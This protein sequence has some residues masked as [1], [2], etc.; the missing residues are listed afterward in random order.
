MSAEP[1][2]RRTREQHMTASHVDADVA[3]SHAAHE[4]AALRH[5]AGQV[6][7]AWHSIYPTLALQHGG[8]QPFTRLA[9]A[10]TALQRLT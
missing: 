4:D 2:E 1:I 7:A 9:E 6:V 10:L 5:A 8:T 3:L